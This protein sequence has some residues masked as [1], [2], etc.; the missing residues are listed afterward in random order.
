MPDGP[1]QDPWYDH[2][3]FFEHKLS[4]PNV[5]DQGKIKSDEEKLRMPNLH[6]TK[7]QVQS[8]IYLPDGQP[9]ECSTRQLSVPTARLS[10]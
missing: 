3:G 10:P 7:E 2:K 6:L 9:G 4:E 8:L 1:A 5:F